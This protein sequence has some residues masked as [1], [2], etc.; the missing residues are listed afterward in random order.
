MKDHQLFVKI[1]KR[2]IKQKILGYDNLKP[3]IVLKD[4][5]I[6]IQFREQYLGFVFSKKNGRLKGLFNWKE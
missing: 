6:I 3:I 5:N 4:K 1:I 2:Q